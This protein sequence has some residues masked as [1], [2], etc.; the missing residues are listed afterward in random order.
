VITMPPIGRWIHQTGTGFNAIAAAAIVIMML[1]TCADVILRL[2]GRPILGTYELVG[3]LGTVVIAF[4]LAYT[5]IEH[6]HIAVEILMERFPAKVQST[7][8]GFNNLI[9]AGLFLLLAWQSSVYALDLKASGEVSLTLAIPTYPFVYGIAA[10]CALL[11]LVL[12]VESIR[13]FRRVARP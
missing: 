11:T 10:G 5:S 2:F 6:G 1:L 8:E 4:A 13:A 12:V 9:G 3:F 7:V